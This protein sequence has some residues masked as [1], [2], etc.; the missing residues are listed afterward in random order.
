MYTFDAEK[1]KNDCVQCIRDFFEEN[2]P[3]CNAVIGISG[4]KDSSIKYLYQKQGL[5][6]AGKTGTAQENKNRP[7]HALFISYAPYDNPD[8]T[9]TVVIPNGYTSSNAAEVARDI[10][11]Y[12]FGKADKKEMEGDKALIPTGPDSSAD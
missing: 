11:R 12:Y 3:G 8:I 9:M 4:G 2:G 7:N 1:V 6:V 10:Y 5:K